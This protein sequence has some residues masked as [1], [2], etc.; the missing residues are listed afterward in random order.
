MFNLRE[1]EKKTNKYNFSKLSFKSLSSKKK[2]TNYIFVNFTTI[3]P[4]C[5]FDVHII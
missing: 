2:E 5:G 4:P 3:I 1:L